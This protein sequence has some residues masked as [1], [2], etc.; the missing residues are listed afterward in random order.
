MSAFKA[1]VEIAQERSARERAR[2]LLLGVEFPRGSLESWAGFD[3]FEPESRVLEPLVTNEGLSFLESHV[4]QSRGVEFRIALLTIAKRRNG[5]EAEESLRKLLLSSD[6]G[7]TSYILAAVSYMFRREE[8]LTLLTR[9]LSDAKFRSDRNL[10]LGAFDL[11]SILGDQASLKFLDGIRTKETIDDDANRMEEMLASMRKRLA[12][13]DSRSAFFSQRDALYY[14]QS[15]YDPIMQPRHGSISMVAALRL[16]LRFDDGGMAKISAEFLRDKLPEP[17]AVAILA[18]Q[19]GES[20]RE[21]LEPIAKGK[22]GAA[23]VAQ[24]SLEYLEKKRR[25]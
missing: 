8:A 6:A 25:E 14:W 2:A 7:A 11:L 19:E 9:V 4:K 17:L 22:D 16:R 1:A 23:R 5:R 20:A 13:I 10:K 3:A 18:V 12:I 24:E 21:L 15:K